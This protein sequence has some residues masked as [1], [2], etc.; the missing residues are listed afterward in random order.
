MV[1]TR[2]VRFIF[3][4]TMRIVRDLR[5]LQ[6]AGN[7]RLTR[8]H[9]IAT[10][11]TVA[12]QGSRDRSTGVSFVVVELYNF[13]YSMSRCLYLSSAFRARDG[14]GKR[15][16]LDVGAS[17]DVDTALTLAIARTRPRIAERKQPP[18]SWG[19]EPYWVNTGV[20]LDSLEGIGA[21]NRPTVAAALALPSKVFS[22]LSPFRH[23]CAHR[24]RQ[25]ARRLRPLIASYSISPALP[26]TDALATPASGPD[27]QRPQVLL[28]D[29]V[30]EVHNVVSLIV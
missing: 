8:L 13:W 17:K 18:W 1:D 16:T 22:H 3:L 19:D 24:N 14:N 15:I 11:A 27:G 25:T 23:F 26:A 21:S 12:P 30:D 2:S 9:A 29:W 10:A 4:D 5:R 20:L 28:L 7:S 6:V